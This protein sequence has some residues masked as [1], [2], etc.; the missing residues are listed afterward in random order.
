MGSNWSDQKIG[1]I[2]FSMVQGTEGKGLY[3]TILSEKGALYHE[4]VVDCGQQLCPQKRY[5]ESCMQTPKEIYQFSEACTLSSF[6]FWIGIKM[7]ILSHVNDIPVT[8]IGKGAYRMNGRTTG[9]IPAT[10][11]VIGSHAFSKSPNIRFINKVNSLQKIGYR[12]FFF[13]W[14]LEEVTLSPQTVEIEDLAF[15]MCRK[16]RIVNIP[17]GLKKIGDAAFMGC[18]NLSQITIPSSVTEVGTEEH[19]SLMDEMGLSSSVFYSCN[20]DFCIITKAGSYA[21]QYAEN[22]KLKCILDSDVP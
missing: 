8:T 7:P 2:Y 22:H 20:R 13:C 5:L 12:A 10:V 3:A 4:Y 21:E 15:A 9:T 14:D 11:K 6:V 19:K 17:Y 18:D 1:G 16:L